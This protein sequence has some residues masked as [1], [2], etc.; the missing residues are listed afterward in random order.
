MHVGGI[1]YDFG[2]AFHYVNHE[3]L[4]VQLHFYGIPDVAEDW[5]RCYVRNRRLKVEV[6]SSNSTKNF[7]CACSTL[8]HGVPQGSILVFHDIFK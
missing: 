7:F 3:I 4:L 6:T 5:F 8:K 2:K 1:F